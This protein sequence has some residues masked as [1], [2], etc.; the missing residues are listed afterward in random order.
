MSDNELHS[1]VD[2]F[3]SLVDQITRET[4][5]GIA[6]TRNDSTGYY[7]SPSSHDIENLR[8]S[9]RSPFPSEDDDDY[10]PVLGKTIHRM[11]TIESLGSREVMSLATS[12]IHRAS[13]GPSYHMSRPSTRSNNFSLSEAGIDTPSI[14][15]RANSLDA[16]LALVSTPT[17]MD[18]PE[19]VW[20]GTVQPTTGSGEVSRSGSHA[21]SSG[22]SELRDPYPPEGQ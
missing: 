18:L 11:P 21:S 16:A 17:T 22:K 6:L 9:H 4:E 2:R 7:A 20:P 15:S 12:S 5:D 13:P 3:R 1:F 8:P 10:V 19:D 14:R